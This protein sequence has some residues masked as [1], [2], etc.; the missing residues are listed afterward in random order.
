MW[1][2]VI[3]LL[4][5]MP[6]GCSLLHVKNTEDPSQPFWPAFLLCLSLSTPKPPAKKLFLGQLGRSGATR[7]LVSALMTTKKKMEICAPC[8][9]RLTK[10][11][12]TD[13]EGEAR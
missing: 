1:V 3:E 4:S 5:P 2:C 8:P 10:R 11:L 9:E 12:C 6:Q 13:V 7:T